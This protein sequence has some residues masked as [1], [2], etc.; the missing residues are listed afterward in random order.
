MLMAGCLAVFMP[1]SFVTVAA[2][3]NAH[4]IPPPGWLETPV[5]AVIPFVPAAIWAYVSWYPASLAILLAGPEK[6]RRLCLAE[7]AAFV[8]CSAVHL[9]WPISIERPP[10]GTLV[11]ASASLLRTLYAVDR[12]VSL[13]PS[14][15]AA[16]TPI[17]LQL[18]PPSWG[19]RIG[20]VAWMA[21]ICLSC[22]LTKQ[23]YLLDVVAGLL[24]GLGSLRLV[25]A[26][27]SSP[28]SYRGRPLRTAFH[29]HTP[30]KREGD[31]GPVV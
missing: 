19:L 23:H 30:P 3:G 26:V 14:F 27:R 10:V 21:A 16:V 13:F 29:D 1:P 20:L 8:L 2:I 17:L 25:D 15:H 12:P 31:H 24:V 22:V 5:D 18:W 11:G 9:L 4:R 7:F 28:P 6:F